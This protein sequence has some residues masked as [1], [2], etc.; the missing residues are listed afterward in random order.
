MKPLREL[1]VPHQSWGLSLD[2]GRDEIAVT[3]QQY[4]GISIYSRTATGAARPLR[5][6]RGENTQ[7]ADPHGVYLDGQ[8]NEVF[9]ANHGNW[10]EMRSYA[11]DAVL[12]PGEYKPGRFEKPSIRIYSAD[13]NGNVPPK[14]TIQG[15]STL[16]AWPMGIH[17]S[18]ERN[19]LAI[20]NY[21]SNSIL[22]FPRSAGG[23]VSPARVIGGE[24]TG[25]IGPV[26]VAF[27]EKNG[28]LWVA[29]YGDHT[30]L[31][32]DI[33]RR[34]QRRTEADHPQ[35]AAGDADHRIHQRVRRGLRQQARR[36]PRP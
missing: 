6:I 4:Q 14:R 35:R 12:L 30:A 36:S 27:D 17:V 34:G 26:G 20:A 7:L 16:L 28:E 25:I 31:V 3:S 24:R 13:A 19:E 18:R 11:D 10:T 8:N 21:G 1:D 32:F 22:V 33:D 9:T 23:D 2:M 5:T 29:N 15:K